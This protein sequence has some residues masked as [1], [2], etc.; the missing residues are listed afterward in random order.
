[1]IIVSP[2]FCLLFIF[3]RLSGLAIYNEMQRVHLVYRIREEAFAVRDKGHG[4][5]AECLLYHRVYVNVTL[6][7][8]CQMCH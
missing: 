5:A 4:L 1:M 2:P 6:L 8:D 7:L 3:P